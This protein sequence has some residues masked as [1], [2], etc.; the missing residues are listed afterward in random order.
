M[1]S[2]DFWRLV[3][4]VGFFDVSSPDGRCRVV[5]LDLVEF[6]RVWSAVCWTVQG[7][8]LGDGRFEDRF[9]GRPVDDV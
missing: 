8:L 2:P 4:V 9:E 6:R 1:G 3:G 5:E 7:R